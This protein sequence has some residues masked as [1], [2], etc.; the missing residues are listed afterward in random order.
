MFRLLA[1]L[2]A[3]ALLLPAQD[4]SLDHLF[5]RPFIW[6]TW[7]SRIAWAK[8]A[9]ILGFLWNARGETFEDLYVYDADAKKLTRLTDLENLK[10]PINESDAEKDEHRKDFL[11]PPAGLTSFDLS[12]DGTKAVFSYRGDLFLVHTQGGPILRL[13]KTKA[14]EVN[15]QF[16]PDGTKIAFTQAGQIYVLNTGGGTLEQRTD[17]R[18]PASLTTF[19]WSPDGKYFVYAVQLTPGRTMPLPNYSG[20]FVAAPTFPRTVAGDT[21]SPWQYYLVESSGDTPPRLLETGH[22]FGFRPPQW[23]EDSKHLVL[24]LQSTDYKSE[25]IRVIDRNTG[26]SKV[27]FHQTDDR[28]V[29]VS[30]TGWDPA[31]Q[32]IW[33]LSDQSGFEHLYTVGLDGASPKQLTKGSW[34]IHNDPFSHGP[35]WAGEYIYYSSTESSTTERQFYRVKGDGSAQPERLSEHKGLNIGW[36][37]EDG[38]NQA[39]LQAD[40]RNPFDL[41]VDGQRVTTSPLPEFYKTPWVESRFL[42]YPSIKDHKSVSARM[43]LPPGYNPDNPNQKQFPAIVYIHGSGIA[44][45]VLNQWGSYQE[46]R[47]VLNEY[48]AHN[49]Y[50]IIEMDYRGST[51]YGRDWRTGVYLDMGGPDLEDVLGGVEYLRGLKNIDMSRV[52]IWGWS[53]GGFMTA[54]AMFRAPNTFKAGAAFSGV[55]N[56]ANYNATYTDERLTS[57]AENPEAYERSSPIYFSNQLRNHLLILHGIVDNNV[58]FQDAVQLTEKLIHESKQFEESFYPEES[59]AYV[60]DES[61]KDAFGRTAKFF[62]RYLQKEHPSAAA[63]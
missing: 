57:P 7:P 31:S 19:K 43:L 16:S 6:G 58:L 11:P 50:V 49:G 34:D 47:F 4:W 9:H 8:H 53:Y 3:C 14:P 35:E 26:K 23:S 28:W 44:T 46:L 22:G 48:L 38:R 45:S 60:R 39:I 5:T 40:M 33:F 18:P 32:H 55:Y 25:D 37:S 63:R 54:M 15:P 61:L 42:T 17:V 36:I 12:E 56:W 24:A 20:E 10:D 59:H 51:N 1:A 62:D 2:F 41:Y 27:V 52:G 13:T 30:D 21:P 29:E